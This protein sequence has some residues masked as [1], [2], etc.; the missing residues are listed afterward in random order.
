MLEKD[1]QKKVLLDLGKLPKCFFYKAQASSLIGIPDIIG[2][3]NG[4]FF[5]LELKRSRTQKPTKMQAYRLR[6]IFRAEGLAFV[7]DPSNWEY[8]YATLQSISEEKENVHAHDKR[9]V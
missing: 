2:C 4:C 5:G 6:Q 7:V 3:V 1:L 9:L 8:V